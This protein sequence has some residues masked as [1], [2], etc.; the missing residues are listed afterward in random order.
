MKYFFKRAQVSCSRRNYPCRPGRRR[1]VALAVG[2]LAATALEV[3]RVPAAALEVE[4]R[5]GQLLGEILG[6]AFGAGGQQGSL[7]FRMTSF[8]KPQS[9]QR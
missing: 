3:G 6:L 5:R 7:T 8:S 9:V 4:A 1:V 2:G